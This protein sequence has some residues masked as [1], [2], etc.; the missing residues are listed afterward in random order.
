MSNIFTEISGLNAREQSLSQLV[1]QLALHADD[2]ASLAKAVGFDDKQ[3]K[4]LKDGIAKYERD[5]SNS[6][7]TLSELLSKTVKSTCCS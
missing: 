4:Q 7:P 6:D 2:G 5:L 3:L 1:L